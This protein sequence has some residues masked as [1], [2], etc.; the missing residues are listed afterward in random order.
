MKKLFVTFLVALFATAVLGQ[1]KTAI[2]P[3]DLPKCVA[4]W[5]KQNMKGFDIDKA[6]RLET[7]SSD[8][9]VVISYYA[10]ATKMKEH[11]WLSIDKNC[12]KVKKI[13]EAEA[14]TDPPKQLPPVKTDPEGNPVQPK[15]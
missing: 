3:P 10:R 7:I 5:V 4:V 6:F 12:G 9:K 13:S 2:K 1:T 15:K 14:Q 8:G 11:Q